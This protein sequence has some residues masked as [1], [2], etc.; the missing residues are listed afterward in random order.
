METSGNTV[1]ITGGATG[2]GLA[3]AK[4][5]L[6]R[7]NKVVICDLKREK[8]AA[9]KKQLPGIGAIPCDVN[10]PQDRQKLLKTVDRQFPKMNILVNNAGVV[11]WHN[12]LAPRPDLPRRIRLEIETNLAAP[13]ELTR[14]FLPR[15]LKQEGA[16]LMNLTSGLAYVPLAAEPV[17]CATKAGLH[18]FS[19]SMRYQLKDT[20]VKVVEVLSSW[21]DTE[22]ARKVDTKK[23]SVE[24]VARETLEG[25]AAGK[26][27][28]HIGS[29]GPLYFMFRL[30]P[31]AFW[32]WL[33]DHTP[34]H[35]EG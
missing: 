31:H 27:E 9:A 23:I 8:L 17:Y 3:L 25:L 22:M 14:L 12:F 5:F 28:I 30:A 18:S 35:R 4:E 34:A 7:G 11:F 2:I 20:K 33:N 29:I 24:R 1:L 13:I 16:C 10:S 32:K 21:V 6:S 15:L 19:Q 26:E